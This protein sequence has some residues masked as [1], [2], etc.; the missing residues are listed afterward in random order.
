MS[1]RELGLSELLLRAVAAEGYA[2][3]TPIQ[4][5]AI[6]VLLAGRDLLGSAQTGTG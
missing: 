6:P 3:A 2:T 1:F 4:L 5:Q